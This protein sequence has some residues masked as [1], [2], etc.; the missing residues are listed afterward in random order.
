[1]TTTLTLADYFQQWMETF[2]KPAVTSV[3]YVKYRNSHKHIYTYFGNIKLKEITRHRYQKG[4]NDFAKNHAKRTTSGFHKQIRAAILDAVEE[5]I[6][7][8]DF[9]RKAIITGR[10]KK[11]AKVMY[12]SYSEWQKLIHYTRSQPLNPNNFIIYLSAM[13]GLRFAE[14]LGITVADIDFKHKLISVNKTWD[15]KYRTGFKETKN[16]SSVRIVDVDTK[17]LKVI[18]E[19]IRFR[20]FRG[21]DKICADDNEK[22]PVSAT[23][24][25]HLEKACQKLKLSSISFHGLRHTHAS[26]LLF[27]GVNILSVSRRL[28]HKDVTTTQSVYLHVIKEMEERETRLI[29]KIMT[30]ALSI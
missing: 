18:K 27:K 3:T 4:L 26:I 6:I 20:R 15:Y 21:D 5:G 23:I 10:E 17:T 29:M 22:L 13:T 1:M 16:A 7:D 28:G 2:K 9:T 30:Q 12:H 8:T 19:V 11:K 14:V 24:N 25:R